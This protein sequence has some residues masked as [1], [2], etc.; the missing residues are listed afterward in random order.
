MLIKKKCN[1]SMVAHTYHWEPE[2]G[3]SLKFWGKPGVQSKFQ[4]S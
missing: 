2:A 3:S 1:L 4:V